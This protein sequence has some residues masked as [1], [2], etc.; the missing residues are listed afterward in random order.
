MINP[1]RERLPRLLERV[2][3]FLQLG[4]FKAT[5]ALLRQ[6]IREQG[7]LAH[8]H[9]WLGV[10]FHRQSRF[11]EAMEQFQQALA[12]SPQFKESALNIVA[13]LLDLGCYDQGRSLFH[14]R[15]L[16]A[17]EDQTASVVESLANQHA[18]LGG[19]YATLG[20]RVEA[21]REY[22]RALSLVPGLADLRLALVSLHLNSQELAAARREVEEVLAR[23]P[24]LVAG[25][26][27]LGIIEHRARN[28][29][30]A[31]RAWEKA[32]RLNPQDPLARAYGSLKLA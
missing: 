14:E 28:E 12:L 17:S 1:T 6:A 30:A 23:Q 16:Q 10:S 7:P 18:S 3:L 20:L 19:Q 4:R 2:R 27:W 31:L 9:N 11:V 24:D 26:V 8:F 25:H 13:T 29:Q 15:A 22:Q 32:L 5:E 21:V